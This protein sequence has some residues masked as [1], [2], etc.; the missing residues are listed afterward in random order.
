MRC[1]REVELFNYGGGFLMLRVVLVQITLLATLLVAAPVGAT[2]ATDICAANADPCVVSSPKTVAAGSI[3][4]L[5]TRQLDVKAGGSL[6]VSSGLM[7]IKAG[8]VRLESGG[9]LVGADVGGNRGSV[10]VETTGDIRLETGGN[11]DAMIEA[12][13]TDNPGNVDLV[14]QGNILIAGQIDSDASSNPGSGGL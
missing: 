14:A 7:T 13:A 3:L 4:D 9:D 12:S 11:G 10:R 2:T 6:T 8:S 5:G 1:A